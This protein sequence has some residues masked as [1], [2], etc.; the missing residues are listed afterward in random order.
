VAI[1]D[2]LRA[3]AATDD[4]REANG[5]TTLL[6]AV[7]LPHRV[8]DTTQEPLTAESPHAA[9]FHLVVSAEDAGRAQALLDAQ[10]EED[11]RSRAD[12]IED[13]SP[14][15]SPWA[16]TLGLAALLSL[17]YW[18]TPGFDGPLSPRLEIES[19]AVRAGEWW[20]LVTAVFLHGDAGHIASNLA[21]LIPAGYFV[22]RRFGSGH[23]FAAFALTGA[24]GNLLSVVAHPPPYISLGASGG[25]FGLW[26]V[27]IGAAFASARARAHPLQRRRELYGAALGLVGL[28]AFSPHADM[29]AH[30]GGLLA[31]VAYGAVPWRRGG[32]AID[33]VMGLCGFAL[34]AAAFHAAAAR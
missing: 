33:R 18:R 9:R 7:A 28:T 4:P 26:G 22:G 1:D 2:Q 25:V 3:V 17:I 31:G 24:L 21:F 16:M 10:R 29:V 27:L 15:G 6:S 19:A 11:E 34:V 32:V 13:D 14:V 30:V 23:M 5:W 8:V 20:R 12:V